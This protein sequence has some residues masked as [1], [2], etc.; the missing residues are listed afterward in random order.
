MAALPLMEVIYP[1]SVIWCV[2]VSPLPLNL[3]TEL[4]NLIH[5]TILG[6][7]E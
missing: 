2:S 3:E 1:V 7:A 6:L 4:T 5:S